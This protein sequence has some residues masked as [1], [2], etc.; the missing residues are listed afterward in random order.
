MRPSAVNLSC[1]DETAFAEDV[2][3]DGEEDETDEIDRES[4][5]SEKDV[6]KTAVLVDAQGHKLI[7]Q[8]FVVEAECDGFRLDRFLQ[9]KIRRLSRARIQR[10]ISGDCDVEGRLARK[11]M[12]VFAG[13][14]VSFRRPAPQEPEVPRNISVVH[15]DPD[16]YVIDKPAGLPIHPTARYHF[17]TLTA[18]LRERFPGQTL[19]VCH[20]LDRETSGLMLVARNAG[21]A[22]VLKTAFQRRLV[23]KRYLAIVHGELDLPD[24]EAWIIDQPMGPAG[25]LVRVKMAV[26]DET[27]GG[28]PAQTVVRV[29][30]RF[31]GHTLVE[32]RPR[33]GRQHQIRVHL[34]HAGFPIVGDKLYPDEKLFLEWSEHGDEAVAHRLTLGRHALHAAGLAFPHPR[35]HAVVRFETDLPDDLSHFLSRLTGPA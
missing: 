1:S 13:Q 5:Q 35:T 4:N 12:R 2:F 27:Q 22:S 16:F 26:C 34:C 18:V 23:E 24:G 10:V 8:R 15:E 31:Y 17:S 14:R 33:T 28:V 30:R 9:K 11:N 19:Q 29:L 7:E 32:C 20:R 25:Q 6:Q 21:A 3:S